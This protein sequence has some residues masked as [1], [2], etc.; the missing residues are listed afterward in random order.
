MDD[1]QKEKVIEDLTNEN[2]Q[3]RFIE[4]NMELIVRANLKDYLPSSK[5]AN[6]PSM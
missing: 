2:K 5:A 3:R 1:E 6:A 4:W